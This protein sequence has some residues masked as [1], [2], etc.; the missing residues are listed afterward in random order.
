V[1]LVGALPYPSP[2]GTQVY[3]RGLV[4]A[5]CAA[6]LDAR[7]ACY[8]YG[9][10]EPDVPVLRAAAPRP[11]SMR[12]GLHPDKVGHD[13][14]LAWALSAAR[15][16]VMHAHGH[17][18]LI[19]ARLA[20]TLGGPRTEAGA[21]APIVYTPHTSLREELPR[22]VGGGVAEGA[23][24]LRP[25]IPGMLTRLGGLLD[26]GLP[27]RAAACVGMSAG[28]D[29]MLR[30]A[31]VQPATPVLP[32]LD[33]EDFPALP[34]P[35]RVPGPPRVVYA[36]N[37][38]GYQDLGVLAEAMR[39]LRRTRGDAAPRL[40]VVGRWTQAER[41]AVAPDEVVDPAGWPEARA[42]I[43]SCDAAVVP[44]AT[45][46][47]VPMK[48]VHAAA[49]GLPVVVTAPVAMGLPGEVVVAPHDPDALMDG[50]VR[51]CAQPRHDGA[52]VV[53]SHGWATR[54]GA[55][56]GGYQ[57]VVAGTHQRPL[58][59]PSP[60]PPPIAASRSSQSVQSSM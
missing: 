1:L 57:R 27:A 32:G 56:I 52:A 49:L 10:G 50:I 37:A 23:G 20:R 43:V 25:M 21:P 42:A 58:S 40:R 7:L 24:P 26:D 5:L 12:S 60:H 47:G 34:R 2:Q 3:L 33:P 31:G 16:E 11:G 22:Y 8:G 19:V 28:T 17:E 15:A 41:D 6:G 36:G 13:L 44:R 14:R 38:D 9:D 59:A 51:A 54:V 55:L 48:L 30:E 45:C 29:R 35:P 53:R 46:A 4:R 18:A 39:R